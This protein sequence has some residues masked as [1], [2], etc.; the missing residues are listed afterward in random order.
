MVRKSPDSS[1]K[2]SVPGGGNWYVRRLPA[3]LCIA[4]F[5]PLDLGRLD[6]DFT[7]NIYIYIYIYIYMN[8]GN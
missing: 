3:E 4:W 1:P 5:L 2:P 8:I 7:I 6:G